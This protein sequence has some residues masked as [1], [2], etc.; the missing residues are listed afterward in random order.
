MVGL[1]DLDERERAAIA[2]SD[3]DA[4][5]M[6]DIDRHGISSVVGNALDSALEGV[7]GLH[8][9]LDMDALDPG[10][11]PGVGTPVHGGITYREAHAAMELIADRWSR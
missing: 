3:I 9:S 6:G 10:E 5:T 8:V 2:D 11:A 7:D 4:Y 1:R